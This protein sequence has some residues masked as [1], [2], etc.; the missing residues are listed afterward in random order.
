LLGLYQQ[1]SPKVEDSCFNEVQTQKQL[2]AD[3][4]VY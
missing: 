3:N 1:E 4:F 2:I